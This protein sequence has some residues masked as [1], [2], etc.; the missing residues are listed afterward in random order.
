MPQGHL[1]ENTS[2]LGLIDYVRKLEERVTTLEQRVDLHEA[3]HPEPF[4]VNVS[5]EAAHLPEI[6]EALASLEQP[7]GR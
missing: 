2:Y 3:E 1:F 7:E 5:K 4:V 6:A